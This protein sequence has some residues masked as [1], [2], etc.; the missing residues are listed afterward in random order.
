[1]RPLVLLALF[2][3]VALADPQ[4]R[5]RRAAWGM[6]G[7][8]AALGATVL[9]CGLGALDASDRFSQKSYVGAVPPSLRAEGDRVFAVALSTDIVAIFAISSAVGAIVLTSVGYRK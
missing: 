7:L 4:E 5:I 8:S 3:Q 6:W 2:S 9:G 1:M